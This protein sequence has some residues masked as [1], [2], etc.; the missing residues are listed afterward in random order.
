MALALLIPLRETGG[1]MQKCGSIIILIAWTFS[2]VNIT[3]A[4]MKEKNTYI[5]FFLQAY[6]F[7]YL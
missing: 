3:Y 6:K 7:E 4:C 2:S 5:Y 1:L